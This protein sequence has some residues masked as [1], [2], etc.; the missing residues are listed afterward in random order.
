VA[1]RFG[2]VSCWVVTKEGEREGHP[3]FVPDLHTS[4][5]VLCPEVDLDDGERWWEGRHHGYSRDGGVR[6]GDGR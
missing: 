5:V 1:K 2:R 6:R 3:T 4:L